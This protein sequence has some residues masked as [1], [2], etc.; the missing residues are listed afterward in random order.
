MGRGIVLA[1]LVL[2]LVGGRWLAGFAMEYAWWHEMGQVETW[3]QMLSYGL[4]PVVAAAVA[5]FALLWVAHARG[6]KHA[7]TG[8]GE[9][10]IYVNYRRWR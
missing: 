9:H 10:P 3:V 6:M 1:V 8:L 4:V 5:A 2:L 7:G